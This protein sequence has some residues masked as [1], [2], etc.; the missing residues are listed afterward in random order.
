MKQDN[1]Q[2]P[3]TYCTFPEVCA[4]SKRTLVVLYSA[5]G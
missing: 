1:T 3:H 2:A 4:T 5:T